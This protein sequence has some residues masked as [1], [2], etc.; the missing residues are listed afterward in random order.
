MRLEIDNRVSTSA[1]AAAAAAADRDLNRHL[2]LDGNYHCGHYVP[3]PDS[4]PMSYIFYGV[5]LAG[6]SCRRRWPPPTTLALTTL[7]G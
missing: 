4:N 6:V 7:L 5:S 2:P 3:V 1:A